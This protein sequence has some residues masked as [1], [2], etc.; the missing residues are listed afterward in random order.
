MSEYNERL[1]RVIHERAAI[2]DELDLINIVL[3]GYKNKLNSLNR[4]ITTIKRYNAL[5]AKIEAGKA[6]QAEIRLHK[7][8]ELDLDAASERREN[9]ILSKVLSVASNEPTP[10][11]KELLRNL[12]DKS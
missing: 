8:D 7:S 4:E 3:V 1:E 2:Q 9:S 5:S 6:S 11:L 12:D 10:L